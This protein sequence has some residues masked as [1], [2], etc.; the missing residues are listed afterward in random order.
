MKINNVNF[1]NIVPQ[2]TEPVKK[3]EQKVQNTQQQKGLIDFVNELVSWKENEKLQ[4]KCPRWDISKI[5]LKY[6]INNCNENDKFIPEFLM[7]A[8]SVFLPWTRA[9]SGLI[10][11]DRVYNEN[12]SDI[13]VNWTDT[14]TKG[15]N[16]EA[17]NANLKVLNNKIEKAEIQIVIFPVI[18]HLAKNEQRIERVRRTALHEL[19][20]ALGL[21]HSNS[22][23]DVMYYRGINNHT[24]SS[25]DMKRLVDLYNSSKIAKEYY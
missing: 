25:N 12:I 23:K 14:I 9:S 19:G 10:R 24:L 15:R 8:Q 5:P 6:F 7:A 21:N 17:G 18:D 4:N 13:T 16:F 11:F 1:N 20:H 3:Y 22:K 2:I